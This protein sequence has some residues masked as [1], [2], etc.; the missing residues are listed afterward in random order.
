M[1]RLIDK[2]LNSGVG[3]RL[4]LVRH[5]EANLEEHSPEK[6]LS[7]RGYKEIERVAAHVAGL[8]VELC[9]I[10]H[11]DKLRAVGTAKVLAAHLSPAKG[12]VK[13]DG[14]DPTDDPE[15]VA[16]L[17]TEKGA[18][19]SMMLVGH[20]PHLSRLAAL[21][22]TGDKDKRV[23]SFSNASVVSLKRCADGVWVVEWMLTPQVVG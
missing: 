15:I 16:R 4:Y 21:L 20:L 12:A 10:F 3:M 23:V 6:E 7:D 13:L 17:I 14:L 19:T 22:L 11:S 2:I 9:C 5:A 18:D 8:S 1:D